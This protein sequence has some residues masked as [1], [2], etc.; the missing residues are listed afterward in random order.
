MELGIVV[1]PALYFLKLSFYFPSGNCLQHYF[2]GIMEY[3]RNL[4]KK[5]QIF[6]KEIFI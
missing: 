3:N 4:L 2:I 6:L 5:Q 1:L